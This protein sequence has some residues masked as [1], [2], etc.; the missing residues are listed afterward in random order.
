[1]VIV[2]ESPGKSRSDGK[3]VRQSLEEARAHHTLNWSNGSHLECELFA[4]CV[5]CINVVRN[6]MALPVRF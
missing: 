1:M 5:P 6:P 2:P 4:S 3:R